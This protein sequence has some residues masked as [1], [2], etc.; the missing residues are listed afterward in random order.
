ML[1]G[2]LIMCVPEE[3]SMLRFAVQAGLGLIMFAV[4]IGIAIEEDS[5]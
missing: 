3:A 4:G 5:Y 2:I 1:V